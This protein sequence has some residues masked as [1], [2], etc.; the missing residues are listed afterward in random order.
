MTELKKVYCP[1]LHGGK[2]WA[3][4]LCRRCDD[5]WKKKRKKDYQVQKVI[6]VYSE[7]SNTRGAWIKRGGRQNLKNE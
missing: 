7:V 5:P 1:F 4:T 3:M 6:N 2:T